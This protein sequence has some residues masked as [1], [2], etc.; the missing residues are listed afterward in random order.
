M[1]ARGNGKSLFP[2]GID[3]RTAVGR[4]FKDHIGDLIVQVG[5]DPSPAQAMLIRRGA[6]LATLAEQDEA[7]LAVGKPVDPQAYMARSKALVGVLKALGLYRV[8]RDVTPA[9]ASAPHDSH[10]RALIDH[11]AD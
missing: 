11:A 9:A 2:R 1:V 7:A 8:P 6:M 5:G 10:T 4:R 3:G